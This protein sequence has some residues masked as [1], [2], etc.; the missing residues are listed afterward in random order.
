VVLVQEEGAEG[1]QYFVFLETSGSA[2]NVAGD[3]AMLQSGTTTAKVISFYYHMYG[4]DIGTLAVEVY[5]GYAWEKVWEVSGQQQNS[6]N[7]EWIQQTLN[8]SN[9]TSS[10]KIRFVATAIGGYRGDIAIDQIRF[11]DTPDAILKY[12]YDALGR[13]VC[14]ED[15]ENG[16]RQYDYDAAGNRDNVS[17]NTCGS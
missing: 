5:N 14:A 13:L 15:S 17:V 12:Q 9:F 11:E 10:K 8:I 7:A 16:N 2:A 6:S 4:A 3:Y 1:S